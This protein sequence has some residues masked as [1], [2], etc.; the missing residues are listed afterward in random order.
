[1]DLTLQRVLDIA[2]EQSGIRRDRLSATTAV[3]QDMRM[4]GDDVEEF[5]STLAAEFGDHI[6]QWPWLRFVNLNEPHLFTGLW[7]IW[8]LLTWPI[9][10]RVY[11]PSPFERLELGHIAAV[12]ENGQW[13]ER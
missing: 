9:R 1:M 13:F 2:A 7:F 3:D 5:A 8:R 4:S 12:I 6:W 11:D 10:G